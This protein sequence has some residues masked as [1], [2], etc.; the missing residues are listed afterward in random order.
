M[1]CF[2]CCDDL[3]TR[4][5]S[6]AHLMAH[7]ESLS[8]LRNT[9]NRALFDAKTSSKTEGTPPEGCWQNQSGYRYHSANFQRHSVHSLRVTSRPPS[10]PGVGHQNHSGTDFDGT[11]T[12]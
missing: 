6:A 12:T 10:C 8:D 11:T 1:R 2:T 4:G 7:P 5:S 9:R 3:P